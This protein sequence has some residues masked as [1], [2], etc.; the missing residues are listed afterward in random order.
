[1]KYKGNDN[2]EWKTAKILSR[3]SKARGKYSTFYNIEDCVSHEK[4]CID[5]KNLNSWETQDE[6][7]LVTS[8]INNDDINNVKQLE[9]SLWKKFNIYDEVPDENHTTLSTRWVITNKD[10][11]KARLVVR[12]FEEEINNPS[13]SPTTSKDTVSI[14]FASCSRFSWNVASIDINKIVQIKSFL[15]GDK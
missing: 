10:K 11:L 2:N 14:F 3:G 6:Q 13:D 12:G 4:Q 5:F 15:Q 1:M 7:I 9:L 8:N